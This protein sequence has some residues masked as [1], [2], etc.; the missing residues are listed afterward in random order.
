MDQWT[1]DYTSCRLAAGS[2]T[3]ARHVL[4]EVMDKERYSDSPGLGN[5]MG[6]TPL[7][8]RTQLS[9]NSSN[10]RPWPKT[11]WCTMGKDAEAIK[12]NDWHRWL[13]CN[14]MV[15]IL[16]YSMWKV[17]CFCTEMQGTFPGKCFKNIKYVRFQVSIMLIPRIWSSGMLCCVQE[18]KNPQL[19]VYYK[20][21]ILLARN[22]FLITI[23]SPR[24]LQPE[25][26]LPM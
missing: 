21:L 22:I 13:S 8:V 10:G 20:G 15:N 19:C 14:S 24:Y 18:D 11:A 1:K 17:K 7:L 26:V 6:L 2:T 9:Q 23:S 12:E 5:G 25:E 3:H 4:S 16:K